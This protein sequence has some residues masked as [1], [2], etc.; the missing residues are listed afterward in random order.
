MKNLVYLASVVFPPRGPTQ[1][2]PVRDCAA[3]RLSCGPPPHPTPAPIHVVPRMPTSKVACSVLWSREPL[4]AGPH[5]LRS[6]QGLSEDCV[7]LI[8]GLALSLPS[9]RVASGLG[10]KT[11]ITP[12][13]VPLRSRI[14][15]V[16]V[17]IFISARSQKSSPASCVPTCR[18]LSSKTWVFRFLPCAQSPSSSA[19]R[20]RRP[21]DMS[22]VRKG[23]VLR[24]LDPVSPHGSAGFRYL[25]TVFIFVQLLRFVFLH[26]T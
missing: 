10:E 11:D 17:F 3:C 6:S 24:T 15:T 20:K 18:P 5:A 7:L 13:S 4:P 8:R 22:C 21:Q 2:N 12:A 26:F 1:C 25:Y 14:L 16:P 19:P 23:S 9:S